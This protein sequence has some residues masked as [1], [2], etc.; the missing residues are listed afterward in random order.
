MAEGNLAV[1]LSHNMSAKHITTVV[2][3]YKTYCQSCF[4]A[5]WQVNACVCSG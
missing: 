1:R 4:Y 5:D 3:G 2:D